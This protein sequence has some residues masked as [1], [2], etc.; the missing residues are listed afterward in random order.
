MLSRGGDIYGGDASFWIG[1]L[2]ALASG[3]C[4]SVYTVWGEGVT[5]RHGSALATAILLGVGGLSLLPLMLISGRQMTI[6]MPPRVWLGTIYL[7]VMAGGVANA[8]WLGALRVI[9]PGRL[10]AFG[11]VSSSYLILP[12]GFCRKGH[13]RVCPALLMVVVGVYLM[14]SDKTTPDAPESRPAESAG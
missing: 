14:M 7:G 13:S 11:Y 12:S 6:A 10:G 3:A 2:L 1:D 8:L 9:S 4:W 5:R